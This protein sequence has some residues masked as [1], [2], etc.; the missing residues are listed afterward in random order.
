MKRG[1]Q[2]RLFDG[3]GV[4]VSKT[5]LIENGVLKTWTLNS[6][7]ARQLELETTGHASRG[8]SSPPGIGLS[9]LYMAAGDLSPT[10]LMADIKDG[11]YIT[12]LIGMGVNGVTGDYSR[13]A[14]GFRI[15]NGEI[16]CP[17]SEVT[18]A[19]NLK[20]M[21]KNIVVGSDLTFKYGTNAPTIRIDGMSI[22][23]A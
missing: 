21:F 15:E 19:S 9:N 6:A 5:N 23:G 3:E 14:A 22:A 20:D 12:E 2:S 13:G 4:T 16:T 11:F 1:L 8:T 10:E 17:V 7:A 18:I